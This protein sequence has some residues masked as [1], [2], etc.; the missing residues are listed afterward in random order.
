M[1]FDPHDVMF[2]LLHH[3]LN[4][5]APFSPSY[6]WIVDY[7]LMGSNMPYCVEINTTNHQIIQK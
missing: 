2:F 1:N 4:L 5:V 3:P 7:S 6:L